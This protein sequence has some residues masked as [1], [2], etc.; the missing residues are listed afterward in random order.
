LICATLIPPSDPVVSQ[1]ES[2][3]L[4]SCRNDEEY[5]TAIVGKV[6]IR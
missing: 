4:I 1:S 6:G 5:S 3:D 2:A